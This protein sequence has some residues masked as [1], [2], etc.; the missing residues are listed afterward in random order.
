MNH[1]GYFYSVSDNRIILAAVKN[2]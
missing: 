2:L 1:Y